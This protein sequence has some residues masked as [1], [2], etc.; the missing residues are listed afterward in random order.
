MT[1]ISMPSA[2]TETVCPGWYDYKLQSIREKC[3]G[4][5]YFSGTVFFISLMG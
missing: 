5:S 2:F 3:N 1:A 4:A